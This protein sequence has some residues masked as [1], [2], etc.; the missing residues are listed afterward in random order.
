MIAIERTLGELRDR[1]EHLIDL[2]GEHTPVGTSVIE[3]LYSP[4]GEW[5]HDL[6]VRLEWVY[7][8]AQS[9][10]MVGEDENC[11]EPKPGEVSAVRLTCPSQ[12]IYK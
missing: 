3:H 4:L 6:G 1:I 10:L 8:D 2:L 11:Y 7:I 5:L 9:G 12:G